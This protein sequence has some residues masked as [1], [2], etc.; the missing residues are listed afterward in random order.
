ME[1]EEIPQSATWMDN[2][3]DITL[4]HKNTN[5]AC[6]YLYGMSRVVKFTKTESRTV[7]AKAWGRWQGGEG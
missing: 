1:G 7:A 4:S 2:L 6:F 3:E 5:T